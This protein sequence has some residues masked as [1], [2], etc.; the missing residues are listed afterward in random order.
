MKKKTKTAVVQSLM[1]KKW[2]MDREAR[3]AFFKFHE[4][5]EYPAEVRE[6]IVE[7]MLKTVNE[8]ESIITL[9]GLCRK[10]GINDDLWQSFVKRY[11]YTK[12][13]E[14]IMRVMGDRREQQ[15]W[16]GAGNFLLY[17]RTAYRYGALW[18]DDDANQM[19]IAAA[20][21]PNIVLYENLASKLVERK[22]VNENVPQVLQS[23]SHQ[24]LFRREEP[25]RE[26]LP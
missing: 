3:K 7:T 10:C 11:D 9:I 19:K 1:P 23:P 25:D 22:K 17:K 5:R 15:T 16:N 4:V 20:Q 12:E 26:D 18:Q 24:T 13:H 6:E 14:Y 21:P 8:N 2:W